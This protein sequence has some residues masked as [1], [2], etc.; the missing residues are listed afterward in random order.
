[1]SSHFVLSLRESY[2]SPS[3]ITVDDL[4]VIAVIDTRT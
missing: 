1:M 3:D 4:T 2:Q